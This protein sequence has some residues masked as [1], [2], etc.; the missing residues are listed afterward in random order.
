MI[1]QES[2][3]TITLEDLP[4][5]TLI[6]V[7][8]FEKYF[9][10]VMASYRLVKKLPTEH[11]EAFSLKEYSISNPKL[12]WKT[13]TLTLKN[14]TI[15]KRQYITFCLHYKGKNSLSGHVSQKNT[16]MVFQSCI[17]TGIPVFKSGYTRKNYLEIT[18]SVP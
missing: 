5:D 18:M 4:G 16:H 7:S 13:Q 17:Q 14:F 11:M 12:N 9:S 10:W 8:H 2:K 1:L 15:T 6:S 3:S